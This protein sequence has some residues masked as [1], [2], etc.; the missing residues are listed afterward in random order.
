MRRHLLLALVPLLTG[1]CT[2]LPR[3][4]D[5][6]QPED[7]DGYLDFAPLFADRGHSNLLLRHDP[8]VMRRLLVSPNLVGPVARSSMKEAV[9]GESPEAS[10][11]AAVPTALSNQLLSYLEQE[12]GSVIITPAM[13]RKWR[14]EWLNRDRSSEPTT[15]YERLLVAP[16]VQDAA[17]ASTGPTAALAISF[18]DRGTFR[19]EVVAEEVLDG[20]TLSIRFRPR[21]AHDDDS[22]CPSM[23]LE[24]PAVMLVGEV[25]E[26]RTG[27]L[28]ARFDAAVPLRPPEELLRPLAEVRRFKAVKKIEYDKYEV[29]PERGPP[30]EYVAS[31]EPIDAFCESAQASLE[32]LLKELTFQERELTQTAAAE[33][34]R[35]TFGTMPR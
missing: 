26:A 15:W 23:S 19:T 29:F 6:P 1:A 33:L 4:P 3:V 30:Y 11:G 28:I 34:L 8:A 17:F 7:A 18:F 27:R 35:E 9:E 14:E 5:A 13:T 2:I 10:L 21:A 16:A 20:E 24:I 32:S 31:W 12:F 22:K 25:L